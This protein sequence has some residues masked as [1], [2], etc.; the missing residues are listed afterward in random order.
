MTESHNY[1]C[2]TCKRH[3]PSGMRARDKHCAAYGHVAP[4][5][6][7]HR[8]PRF[9]K[10]E[11]ARSQHEW[12]ENHSPYSCELCERTFPTSSTQWVHCTKA[13]GR[14]TCGECN[15]AFR[16]Q[17]E[18]DDHFDNE[19]EYY[20]PQCY[21]VWPTQ[22]EFD[23]HEW[24]V[25]MEDCRWCPGLF[26][27]TT[28]EL[29]D[30]EQKVHGL[31]TCGKCGD[32][33]AAQR[34]LAEHEGRYHA[35]EKCP[36]CGKD[37]LTRAQLELHV[38]G[39]RFECEWC[40]EVFDTSYGRQ[41]HE[42]DVH[43]AYYC[44]ECC[45]LSYSARDHLRHR[46]LHVDGYRCALCKKA[47]GNEQ[48]LFDHERRDHFFCHEC[49]R[50]FGDRNQIE[51]HLRS[52]AHIGR[53]LPCPYC[54]G[55]FTTAAGLVHHLERQACPAAPRVGIRELCH[56]IAC[57]EPMGYL[58]SAIFYKNTVAF[59]KTWATEAT[60]YRESARSWR[61]SLCTI[62][63]VTGKEREFPSREA[64]MKHLNSSARE[65]RG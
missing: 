56:S 41:D 28:E 23:D 20:C 4:P 14:W 12:K 36:E 16:S 6:E 64:L 59:R 17:A 19:H 1:T 51:Q 15:G 25:H 34:E 54:K 45:E 10:T 46:L 50:R 63:G 47:F 11:S 7:C 44:H 2:G 26:F 24:N 52:R 62:N 31:Y 58:R 9:F 39:H 65:Y 33:F 8:C 61:C 38:A 22:S 27:P 42:V 40:S 55:A 3:F 5:Y 29:R 53:P 35:T 30:H 48:F 32:E 13:H 49:S 43:N 18:L 60:A 57:R 21:T 37:G